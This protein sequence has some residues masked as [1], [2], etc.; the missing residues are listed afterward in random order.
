MNRRQAMAAI[1]ASGLA[2]TGEAEAA[3]P[4]PVLK[5]SVVLPE[6]YGLDDK[7]THPATLRNVGYGLRFVVVVENVSPENVYVW[8]E[9]N[10]EGHGTLSFEI[11]AGGKKT[12][13]SR[14]GRDWSKNILRLEKL[15]P[16][17]LHTRVVEYDTLT[18]KRPQWEAFPFGAKD[19][20][21]DVTLRAVFEQKKSDGD[22]KLTP[23]AGR[24]ASS[25]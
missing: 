16:G 5:V 20:R 11:E 15:V 10:S 13:V 25:D 3:Q 8:N 17:G 6:L 18:G 2:L 12:V 24:V 21:L 7:V 22:A 14:V 1:G 4:A 9:G 19:S 23:W